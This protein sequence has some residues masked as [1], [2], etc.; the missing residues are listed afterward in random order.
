MRV[1]LFRS[2]F[3][4]RPSHCSAYKDSRFNQN[5]DKKT[6][7][8]TKSIITVCVCP[9]YLCVCPCHSLTSHTLILSLSLT[10]TQVPIIDWNFKCVGVIQAINKKNQQT[11]T[12]DD[13]ANLEHLATSAGIVLRKATLYESA[14]NSKHKAD[15]LMHVLKIVNNKTNSMTAVI[16]E[17]LNV[18]SA[19]TSSEEVRLFFVSPHEKSYFCLEGDKYSTKFSIAGFVAEHGITVTLSDA[20]DDSKFDPKEDEGKDRKDRTRSLICVPV[21]DSDGGVMAV[22]QAVN[23]R[24]H[25]GVRPMSE[26]SSAPGK[27]SGDDNGG[28]RA[29]RSRPVTPLARDSMGMRSSATSTDSERDMLYASYDSY[30]EDV[31]DAMCYQVRTTIRRFLH[32]AM[33]K[34]LQNSSADELSILD[35]YSASDRSTSEPEEVDSKSARKHQRKKSILVFPMMH[36]TSDSRGQL[37]ALRNFRTF[38][39]WEHSDDDLLGF[40]LVMFRD[41]NLLE[42]PCKIDLN[43][44][45]SFVVH[46]SKGYRKNPFHNWKHGFSALHFTYLSLRVMSKAADYLNPMDLLGVMIASLCHDVDHP[47]VTNSFEIAS[48]SDLALTHNDIHVL[49]NHHAHTMF[50]ILQRDNILANLTR[51]E[52]KE[53]R[54]VMINGILATDLSCHFDDLKKLDAIEIPECI[55]DAL[56]KPLFD[57]EDPAQRRFVVNA[58]IHNSDLR[59]VVPTCMCPLSFFCL[60]YSHVDFSICLFACSAQTFP[61]SVAAR[62][63][64]AISLEFEAQ[65][66]RETDLGL[67]VAPFMQ[68]LSDPYRC[69]HTLQCMSVCVYPSFL[70]V[71]PWHSLH[72]NT[73][74]YLWTLFLSLSHTHIHTHRRNHLQVNFIKF[75][76]NPWWASISRV[77]PG[78]KESF[79]QLQDNQE[80]YANLAKRPSEAEEEAK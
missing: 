2:L 69:A 29:G 45:K 51:A 6:S 34:T 77:F 43:V 68:N 5:V 18:I 3:F 46:V 72:T 64:Q 37:E 53:L 14:L 48:S 50:K 10:H 67:P 30:D 22:I 71:C 4:S 20:Y 27:E 26:L 52:Q 55:D 23:K 25:G 66:K 1:Q 24:K 79:K 58:I 9:S 11:F 7:F 74:S 54:S 41:M 56:A 70:C 12:S 73:F 35:L 42:E 49:E 31:M 15:A 28:R 80:Y 32:P 61:T 19:V 33:R 62:W 59:C 17:M 38:N 63:E 76:L 44:F 39:V 36:P 16:D 60:S 21:K 65:A 57:I 47:G 75:V 40:T 13:V 78:F 8:I